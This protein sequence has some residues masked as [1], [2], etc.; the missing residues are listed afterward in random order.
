MGALGVVAAL[1]AIGIALN[2]LQSTP[3]NP[4]DPAASAAAVEN[5]RDPLEPRLL[6]N[7][8]PIRVHV[9]GAVK[10]P[11]VYTFQSW[12]RVEEAVKKAGGALANAD[13]DSI[14]L[15]DF[16]KDGEQVRIPTHGRA[17]ALQTHR[18]TPEPPPLPPTTGGVGSGRYPFS[19]PTRPQGAAS[20]EPFSIN[21]ATPEQLEALPGIGKAIASRIIEHR[22]E[23]GPFVQLEDLMNVRGI[24]KA[25]FEKLRPYVS[26]P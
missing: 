15:A 18:P 12:S 26:V 6:P 17:A 11:G 25:T 16:L 8:R 3:P 13:L 21:T 10:R 14:N 1:T 9:A 19:Q 4:H 2:G 20:P 5:G 7:T 24:G 22:D 23:H